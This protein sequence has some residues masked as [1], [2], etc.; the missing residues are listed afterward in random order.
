[1]LVL[2]IPLYFCLHEDDDL[3]LKHVEGSKFMYTLKLYYVYMLVCINNN[4]YLIVCSVILYLP[5]YQT[6]AIQL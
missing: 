2:H 5:K 4:Q 1:V 3:S 6:T